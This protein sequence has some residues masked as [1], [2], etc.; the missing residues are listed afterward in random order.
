MHHFIKC[1]CTKCLIKK[2]REAKIFALQNQID[3]AKEIGDLGKVGIIEKELEK[4][5]KEEEEVEK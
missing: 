5:E 4:T 2:R 3:K 1:N